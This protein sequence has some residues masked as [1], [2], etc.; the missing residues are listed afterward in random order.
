M[1]ISSQRGEKRVLFFDL[2]EEFLQDTAI[3]WQ[4]LEKKLGVISLH[5]VRCAAVRVPFELLLVTKNNKCG[6]INFSFSLVL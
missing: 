4:P 3:P 6:G 1:I 5:A 2:V